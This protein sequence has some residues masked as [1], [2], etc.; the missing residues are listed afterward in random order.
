[1][2]DATY[3]TASDHGVSSL[4]FSTSLP[5]TNWHN[6]LF[7]VSFSFAEEGQSLGLGKNRASG[8]PL[9]VRYARVEI[10][11]VRGTAPRETDAPAIRGRGGLSYLSL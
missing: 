3:A 1:L 8:V 4:V 11:I 2:K 9:S 6:F 10:G 5:V 7:L